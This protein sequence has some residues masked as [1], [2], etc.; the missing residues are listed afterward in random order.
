MKI[1]IYTAR[2]NIYGAREIMNMDPVAFDFVP[3][4]KRGLRNRSR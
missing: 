3:E 1:G 2:K 4:K